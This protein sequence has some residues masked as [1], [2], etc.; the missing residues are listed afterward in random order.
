MKVNEASYIF[1]KGGKLN[2]IGF[3]KTQKGQWYQQQKK[4][5]QIFICFFHVNKCYYN[6]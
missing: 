6:G 2:E 1:F 5:S 3:V 4:V